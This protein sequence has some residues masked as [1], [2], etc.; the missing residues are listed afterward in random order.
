MRVTLIL[1]FILAALAA[2]FYLGRRSVNVTETTTVEYRD[3]P[4]VHVSIDAPEPLRFAVPELPQFIWRT[5]TITRQQ[6]I[7]TAAIIDD[8][9]LCREYGGRLINDT[10]GTV[11][12]FAIVQYNRLQNIS[13]DYTPTQR[14]VT[15]TKTIQSRFTPFI[16][17][18]ANTAG[19]GQIE[20]GVLF[21]RWGA[22]AEFGMNFSGRNYVSGKIGVK[23]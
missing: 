14:T 4:S 7:D 18:G 8:W 23:F 3:M 1:T 10:T 9:I 5:D 6:I 16:L 12:Y 21:R 2:G 17:V 11:D 15:T 22:S 20:G 19:F 13:L